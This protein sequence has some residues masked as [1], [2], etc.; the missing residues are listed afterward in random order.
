[1]LRFLLVC[2]LLL[3]GCGQGDT[4]PVIPER[5]QVKAI[6]V[7]D[8]LAPFAPVT[9]AG[10][11]EIFA[12]RNEYEGFQ[13][14]VTP[15]KAGASN[16]NVTV[17]P[18]RNAAG[19]SL[20]VKVFR[21]RY[22]KVSQPSPF[23][24]YPPQSWP[25]ILLPAQE[26][27]GRAAEFRAFPQDLG[28][29]E[30]L[31]VWAEV[32]VPVEA[33]PGQYT[34]TVSVTAQGMETL[35]LPVTLT[36]WDFALPQRSP[37]R[38]VFGTNGFRVA[39]V[40]GFERTGDNPADNRIIRAYNDF[41]LDH[42]L[43]PESF[44]D[45][46]PLR[47]EHD[48]PGFGRKFAGLGTVTDNMRHYMQDKHASVYTY[49]FG[50]TYPFDDALGKQHGQ[51]LRYMAD[52]ADWC[53]RLAGET[54]RCY[55][56]PSFLDEPNSA[57]AYAAVRRWGKFF[58]EVEALTR[59]PIRFQVSEQPTPDDPVWGDLYGAVDVWVPRFYDLWRDVD[60]RGEN[61]SR[62]RLGKGEELWAYTALVV[63]M[64][65]YRKLNPRADVL[66]GNYPPVWQLDYPAINYRIP[67]WFLHQY[68]VTGLGYWET[69]MWFPGADVWN[70][71]AS[72]KSQD[73]DQ[74]VFNGDGLLV[75][76]GYRSTVGFDG[77]IPSLRLKWIRESVE[78]YMYIDLLLQAGEQDFVNAQIRRFA[79][80]LGD[81]D[82][83][84]ALLMQV[85]QQMGERLQQVLARKR[86]KA[87]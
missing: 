76:P 65:E 33:K 72:F 4:A 5:L 1:M 53:E 69:F 87:P 52:Y 34:C 27:A 73:A 51:A 9:G 17:S 79:R 62:A 10:Q 32:H 57:D 3:S 26:T 68:G 41:L 55:T 25:D 22:V 24:P 39:E 48:L 44:W 6:G 2:W 45:A 47:D 15:G 14:V 49:E 60:Y 71:A 77:P 81:W 63:D 40:Y 29:G 23:S 31:P 67:T 19:D 58:D 78:D 42:Y 80:N 35:S 59:Q 36:V 18:L 85:R 74:T 61:V 86:G 46:I 8:R 64:A 38:T 66:K 56:N 21:E 13:F 30:N 75:Y 7:M 83:D 12:A 43:S 84:P 28:S 70:D 54:R 37:L 50:D 11:V 82:N 20:A 16:V